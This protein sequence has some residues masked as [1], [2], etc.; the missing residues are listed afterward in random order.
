[1][2]QQN[3]A[4]AL[5]RRFCHIY[6]VQ[7][8]LKQRQPTK[9]EAKSLDYAIDDLVKAL[10]RDLQKKYGRVD[11]TRLRKDGFSD[12]LLSRLRQA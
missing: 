5:P 1:M 9:S 8:G 7:E 6:D 3:I 11:Y 12:K 10:K 2:P 4:I